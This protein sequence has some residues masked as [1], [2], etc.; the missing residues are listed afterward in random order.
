MVFPSNAATSS[1]WS[2][3]TRINWK[4]WRTERIIIIVSDFFKLSHAGQ[5]GLRSR[6]QRIS[7]K[8]LS[9]SRLRSRQ[10]FET[11][12][13]TITSQLCWAL[14][15][16]LTFLNHVM[17]KIHFDSFPLHLQIIESHYSIVIEPFRLISLETASTKTIFRYFCSLNTVV[18]M[19]CSLIY[20]WSAASIADVHYSCSA[21]CQ[22]SFKVS[23]YDP[24]K[25]YHHPHLLWKPKHFLRI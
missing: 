11:V 1:E 24:M 8:L 12:S 20:H 13:S 7:L 15:I 3:Y 19:L 4:L 18:Y 23:H 9:C 14:P 2:F 22:Y 6:S 10:A 16:T 17:R 21:N 25:M 5:N